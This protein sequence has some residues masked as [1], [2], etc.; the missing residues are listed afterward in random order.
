[1]KEKVLKTKKAAVTENGYSRIQSFCDAVK[2]K[3][4]GQVK[5]LIAL[6]N[7]KYVSRGG[8]DNIRESA[9]VCKMGVHVLKGMGTL[10]LDGEDYKLN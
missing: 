3:G 10:S 2:A 9:W 8:K 1:M 7:K 6:A 5:D 4:K